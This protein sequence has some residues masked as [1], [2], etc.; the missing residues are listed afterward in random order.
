MFTHPRMVRDGNTLEVH[1]WPPN[2]LGTYFFL[3]RIWILALLKSTNNKIGAEQS[4]C[5]LK[6]RVPF[7]LLS[8]NNAERDE[9][10]LRGADQAE[11]GSVS[12]SK[13]TQV[14]KYSIKAQ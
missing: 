8:G 12:E 1:L 7:S 10:I 4:P 11:H 6:F 9:Q 5:Y 2:L 3:H 14:A 13:S